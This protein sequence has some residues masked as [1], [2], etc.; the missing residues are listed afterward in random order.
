MDFLNTQFQISYIKETPP[1][2]LRLMNYIKKQ[3]ASCHESGEC[4]L[5]S[6]SAELSIIGQSTNFYIISEK[7][8]K[9]TLSSGESFENMEV[10]AYSGKNKVSVSIANQSQS[11]NRVMYAA[12]TICTE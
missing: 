7:P 10:F 11:E 6:N 8:I 2:N 5:Q 3:K 1:E 9:I 4:V 12:G